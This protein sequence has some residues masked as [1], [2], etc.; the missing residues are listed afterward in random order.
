MMFLF[1]SENIYRF[2]L[3]R[4]TEKRNLN[5]EIGLGDISNMMIVR[6]SSAI[7]Y[8]ELDRLAVNLITCFQMEQH[9]KV[10]VEERPPICL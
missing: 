6:I 8:I 10:V 5:C 3:L 9:L 2:F 4:Y 7:N 1:S